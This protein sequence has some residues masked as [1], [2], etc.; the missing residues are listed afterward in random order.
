MAKEFFKDLPNTTTP[1][2]AT[3]LNG[4]LDGDEALGNLVVDSIRSK[5]M[6]D[7]YIPSTN[8]LGVTTSMQSTQ[9]K[10]NGTSTGS[11]NLYYKESNSFTLSAGTYTISTRIL[12]GTFTRNSKEIAIYVRNMSQGS[13]GTNVFESLSSG[14]YTKATTITINSDSTFT[15]YL[16]VNGSGFVANNLIIGC[17]IEKGDVATSYSDYQNLNNEE[18]YTTGEHRIGTW[19]D[20]KPLYRKTISIGYLPN[21]TSKQISTGLSSI[22]E[23]TK[24]QGACYGGGVSFPIPNT[25]TNALGNQIMAYLIDNYANL[26]VQTGSDRSMLQGYITIEYTKTTD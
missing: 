25:S 6:L 24:L 4:L 2:T 1:L 26:I 14:N 22:S 16:Y 9:L 7:Y 18:L 23:I 11:G 5:N 20:G 19:I 17:Q 8:I 15:L 12:S 10:I 3:R 21:S 13:T